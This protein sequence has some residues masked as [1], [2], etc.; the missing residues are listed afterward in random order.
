MGAGP[1]LTRLQQPAAYAGTGIACTVAVG[2]TGRGKD[3]PLATCSWRAHPFA[4]IMQPRS[5]CAPRLP[6]NPTRRPAPPCPHIAPAA[7]WHRR[8]LLASEFHDDEQLN[9]LEALLVQLGAR[10]VVLLKA[11]A[12]PDARS[13][14]R[15]V[16]LTGGRQRSLGP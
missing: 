3:K 5:P 12:P 10:E 4:P 16:L 2:V 8:Q 9:A 1:P 15:P 6:A 14:P 13:L 7:L 11:S